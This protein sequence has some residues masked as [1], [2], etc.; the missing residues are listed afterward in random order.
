[1]RLRSRIAPDRRAT[2]CPVV[3]CPMGTKFFGGLS[4]ANCT[5]GE[6]QEWTNQYA[7][8]IDEK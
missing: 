1:M 2:T 3:I 5:T 6:A 4:V 8:T 7:F